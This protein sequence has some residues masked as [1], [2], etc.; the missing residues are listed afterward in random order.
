MKKALL[1]VVSGLCGI[2]TSAASQE[3]SLSIYSGYQTSPHA[4]ISGTDPGNAVDS[5]VD[6]TPAWEGRSF[7]MPPY[8]GVRGTWWRNETLGFGLEFN[9][10]KTY[11]EETAMVANGFS[12]MEFTDGLN[13]ITANVYRRWPDRLGSW[14]PYLGGGVGVS[15]P[16]VDV[17]SDGG[18]TFGYQLTGP[19][20]TW[21][22]G[23]SY[24]I[25]ETWDAFV[26]YKG[27]YSQNKADLDNG[28]S[29]EV[30]FITNALNLGLTFSF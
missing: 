27:T 22:A 9:H 17:E 23:A 26:E 2:A 1:A 8:Y 5:N 28:G 6:F 4:S 14:T 15:V 7:E 16:H 12:S 30:D 10:A 20:V 25:N 18:K 13:I 19:A 11:A 3:F 29:L 24:P 21:I